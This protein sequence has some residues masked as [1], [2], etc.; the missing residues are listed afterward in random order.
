MFYVW[1]TRSLDP[2]RVFK[3][4]G[5]SLKIDFASAMSTCY[6]FNP[7]PNHYKLDISLSLLKQSNYLL[8][9]SKNILKISKKIHDAK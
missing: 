1:F 2:E 4:H 7:F 5:T 6:G 8:K 9:I 3:R